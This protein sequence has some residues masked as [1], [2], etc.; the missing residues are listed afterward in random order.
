MNEFLNELLGMEC[1]HFPLTGD[2]NY[3]IPTHG[4]NIPSRLST[5]T[6]EIFRRFDKSIPD[7]F[8]EFKQ[9]I[10]SA[11]HQLMTLQLEQRGI[12]RDNMN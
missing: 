12:W 5:L 3:Q 10:Y 4:L 6:A 7:D 2:T 11:N 9:W 8:P 1:S